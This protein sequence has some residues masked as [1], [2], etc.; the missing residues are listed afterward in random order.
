MKDN[1][2]K[3]V[4]SGSE[5]K[6]IAWEVCKWGRSYCDKPC[7]NTYL[8]IHDKEIVDK[9][10]S[11]E[12]REYE[13]GSWKDKQVVAK[14]II[15]GLAWNGGQTYYHQITECKGRYIKVGDDYQHSWDEGRDYDE[16]QLI[17]RIK[18][19]SKELFE[20]FDIKDEGLKHKETGL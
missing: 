20:Q 18:N 3:L 6:G 12:V 13:L 15:E 11:E 8:I 14:E 2:P 19:I 1:E 4:W 9:L 5:H 16:K 10:W 17:A 7:W